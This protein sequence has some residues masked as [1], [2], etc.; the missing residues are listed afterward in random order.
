MSNEPDVGEAAHRLGQSLGTLLDSASGFA[1]AGLDAAGSGIRAGRRRR[2]TILISGGCLLFLLFL[3]ALFA[4]FAV[5]AAFWETHRVLAISAV[6]G[7]YL[8]MAGMAGAILWANL[9][10]RP[11]AIDWAAQLVPLVVAFWRQRR[12]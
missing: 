5:I 6:A 10:R 1:R 12:R 2:M 8:L 11:T 3:A 4:G 9:R 7:G